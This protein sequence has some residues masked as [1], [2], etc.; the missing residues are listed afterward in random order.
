[1]Y[2]I[3]APKPLATRIASV[4]PN[5]SSGENILSTDWAQLNPFLKAALAS[6]VLLLME[7]GVSENRFFL[8][9]L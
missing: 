9:N 2:P 1:M 8:N 3:P 6:W 4:R 7:D 5:P